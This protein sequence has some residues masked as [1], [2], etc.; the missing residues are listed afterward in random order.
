MTPTIN[1]A[2]ASYILSLTEWLQWV[3]YKTTAYGP[4]VNHHFIQDN[5]KKSWYPT[6][7]NM[8][9]VLQKLLNDELI[10]LLILA[11]S[12]NIMTL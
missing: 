12:R 5:N 1:Y 8:T 11:K 4:L 2:T 6:A 9:H 10:T 7:D 3:E